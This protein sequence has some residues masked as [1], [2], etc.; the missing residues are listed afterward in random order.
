MVLGNCIFI[1]VISASHSYRRSSPEKSVSNPSATP[2][3]YCSRRRRKA[4]HWSKIPGDRTPLHDD[5]TQHYLKNSKG[6]D[7]YPLQK[8]YTV[9]VI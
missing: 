9:Q 3:E 4:V 5:A 6:L 1:V 8:R 2:K 7:I